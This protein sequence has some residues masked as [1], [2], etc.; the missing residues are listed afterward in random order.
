MRIHRVG[1]RGMDCNIF[2]CVDEEAKR[3]DL[4]DAGIGQDHDRIV[5]EIRAVVDSAAIR[6]VAI[7]HEHLDHVNGLPHWKALGAEVVAS[8]PAAD[9]LHRGHDPTS[10]M[11]GHDIPRLDSDETVQDG[12]TVRL[13][14]R[15]FEVLATP[16]HCPGAVCYWNEADGILFGGDTVFADGGIGRFD[17]PDGDLPTLAASIRR[18]AAL[19]VQALHC[20]HGP[21]V[22]G[23]D[24]A[25]SLQGSLRHVQACL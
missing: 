15:A 18:L 10:A 7:T 3:F 4:V 21:S 22:E 16:G 13:G 11:F 6:R 25:R 19:P 8:V 12:D 14:G 2:V 9:K 23:E 17:F 5:E 20:G 1:G 24:A